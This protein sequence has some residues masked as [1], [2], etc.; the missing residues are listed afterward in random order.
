MVYCAGVMMAVTAGDNGARQ[1]Q[2]LSRMLG[3]CYGGQPYMAMHPFG[4]QGFNNFRNRTV[5][6]N[7]MFSALVFSL[8]PDIKVED[9]EQDE[10]AE[11]L[12]HGQN[13][14]ESC[15]NT[16]QMLRQIIMHAHYLDWAKLSLFVAN[17]QIS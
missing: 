13:I 17:N 5:H 2:R 3:N 9:S 15:A 7:L 14:S 6:G 1:L 11:L 4:E 10:I 8:E 16:M 12:D